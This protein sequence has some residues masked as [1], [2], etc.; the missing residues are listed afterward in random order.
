MFRGDKPAKPTLSEHADY[1]S[2]ILHQMDYNRVIRIKL[3]EKKKVCFRLFCWKK[4]GQLVGLIFSPSDSKEK[5]IVSN[6]HF[7]SDVL[8]KI[9]V[10]ACEIWS[11]RN[12]NNFFFSQ[13]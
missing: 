6:V 3:I 7:L 11:I 5:N 1:I 12:V 4:L 2:I 9:Q 13:P 8:I 10:G